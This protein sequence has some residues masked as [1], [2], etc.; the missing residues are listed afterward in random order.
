MVRFKNYIL[1]YPNIAYAN[2][3]CDYD[4]IVDGIIYTINNSVY[5]INNNKK[6]CENI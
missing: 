3:L 4:L 6:Q 2:R 5:A 1:Y